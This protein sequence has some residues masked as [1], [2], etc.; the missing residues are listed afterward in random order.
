MTFKYFMLGVL[1]APARV[2]GYMM[3]F[4]FGATARKKDGSVDE[5]HS[6]S[7]IVGLV[8]QGATGL[9]DLVKSIGRGLTG[10]VSNHQRAIAAAFWM[11]LLAAGAATGV[12][13]FLPTVFAAVVNYSIAGYSIASV[14][15]ANFAVQAG[16]TA[17]L[18]ALLASTAVYTV[19]A[20]ANF[21]N[22]I[23]SC[24]CTKPD[25]ANEAD[26]VAGE[27][28]PSNRSAKALAALH[29]NQGP[30]ADAREEVKPVHTASVHAS[31]PQTS[32]KDLEQTA[33]D[34]MAATL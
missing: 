11:S 27:P 31:A 9:L 34:H 21:V 30:R 15:G 32:E 23:K 8:V 19:A 3:A 17:G 26:F 28:Q 4:V 20:L 2:L 25:S 16:V 18:S 29:S 10:L 13:F 14:F 24:C 6:F 12:A 33:Q 7:G 22:F 5:K 1:N